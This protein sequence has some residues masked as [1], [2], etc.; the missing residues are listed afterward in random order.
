[1]NGVWITRLED[2][3]AGAGARVAVKDLF[4]TAGLRTTY[5]SRVF[6]H[7]VPTASARAVELLEAAGYATAG[8]TNLHEFAFGITSQNPHYGTVPNPAFPGRT[9]GGSTGGSAAAIAL[10]EADL[11]LGTDSGGSLRI[12][13]ACCELVGFKPSYGRVPLD[14]AFPLAPSFD[15]AGP[16]TRDVA[17]CAA[18]M[19]A[20]ADLEP[21]ALGS[22]ADLEVGVAWT[23]AADPQVRE[24]VEAVAARFPRRRSVGL[25]TA[26][27]VFPAFQAEIAEVHREL[28][29]R[30]GSD[31]GANV[32]AKVASCL[33]LPASQAAAGLEAR[34]RYAEEFHAA[35]EGLD[36]LLAPTLP[37][38]PPAADVDELEVRARMTELTFPLNVVGAPALAL[39]CGRSREGLPVSVQ[40]IGRPRSDELVLGAAAALEDALGHT[41]RPGRSR[42]EKEGA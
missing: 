23:E 39:P 37:L 1:M 11:G 22:L 29:A 19:A 27:G 17:G 32:A 5:G 21:M 28:F 31:Y 35:I 7:N 38:L 34:E 33:E 6:A 42:N 26:V 12:P 15:H 30:H 40:V 41:A 13:A 3:G 14:G 2:P 4:D 8:K 16:I 20:L 24:L 10:G 9:A 36:L 25:R 18:A